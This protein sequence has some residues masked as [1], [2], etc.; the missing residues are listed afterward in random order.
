MAYKPNKQKD[1]YAPDDRCPTPEAVIDEF[2]KQGHV[3]VPPGAPTDGFQFARWWMALQIPGDDFAEAAFQT[4]NKNGEKVWETPYHDRLLY[5]LRK[6]LK[7]S[8]A[9][10]LYIIENTKEGVFW[11]GDDIDTYIKIVEET[12]KMNQDKNQYIEDSIA[13]MKKVLGAMGS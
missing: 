6:F 10:Q 5:T 11:K 13:Q 1:N 4:T 8:K 2:L 12:K 3:R 7:L 9:H